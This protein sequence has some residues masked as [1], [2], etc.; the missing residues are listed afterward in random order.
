MNPGI[1]SIAAFT[2]GYFGFLEQ[3]GVRSAVLHGGEDGFERKLSDVDLVVDSAGYKRI[4]HLTRKYCESSGWL[5]CQILQHET[6]ASYLVCC[7]SSDPGQAVALDVCSDYQRNGT[8]FLTADQ[9]LENRVRL[10][11]GGFGLKPDTELMYRFAKSAA[12]GKDPKASHEEFS[13]YPESAKAGC[14][15][16]LADRFGISINDW[17]EEQV[18]TS[19]AALQS[20][21][22]HRPPLSQ[23]RS[24]KR[25][26]SRM[27]QPTGMVVVTGA[28]RFKSTAVELQ[29]IF[30]GLFF[31][32]YREVSSWHATLAND[33]LIST[34]IVVPH[35]P[36]P[37]R[38]LIPG[39]A[40]FHV[41]GSGSQDPI[42]VAL[43]AR[44]AVRCARWHP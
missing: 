1:R 33:L 34:L 36:F 26:V 22:R 40:Q 7:D 2:R 32:R 35:L 38:N 25:V 6:T 17:T 41:S 44:L 24:L 21:C 19:L 4:G 9:L 3:Q 18:A 16:W 39:S 11:W 12:K 13:N 10:T 23:P 27:C 28:E 8:A 43:A 15:H 30:D 29:P 5:L 20:R 37:W 14:A 42:S 31:R